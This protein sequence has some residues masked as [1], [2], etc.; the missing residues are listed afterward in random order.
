V[1]ATLKEQLQRQAD[2]V[3]MVSPKTG[4]RLCNTRWRKMK[5]R[6][7]SGRIDLRVKIGYSQEQRRW[8][9]PIKLS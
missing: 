4:E 9:N 3:A 1:C 8:L 7:V 2:Q 6:T 5:L